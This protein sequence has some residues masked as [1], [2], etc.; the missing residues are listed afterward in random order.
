VSPVCQESF[1]P[2]ELVADQAV[3]AGQPATSKTYEHEAALH[4][5]RPRRRGLGALL[6]CSCFGGAVSEAGSSVAITEQCSSSLACTGSG[7][8]DLGAMPVHPSLDLVLARHSGSPCKAG[9]VSRRS[10]SPR[11]FHHG[12]SV[13]RASSTAHSDVDWHDAESHFSGTSSDQDQAL[14]EVAQMIKEAHLGP[15]GKAAPW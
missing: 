11:K 8:S 14:E 10:S 15:L 6:R 4:Q 9:S 1:S 12:S 7:H 5:Q 3:V 2:F 13:K